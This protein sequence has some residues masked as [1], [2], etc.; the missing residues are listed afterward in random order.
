MPSCSLLNPDRISVDRPSGGG[1][2]FPPLLRLDPFRSACVINPA[3]S[4]RLACRGACL[5]GGCCLE[6]ALLHVPKI[7]DPDSILGRD[8]PLIGIGRL[9]PRISQ[10]EAYRSAFLRDG[11][12]HP[13]RV[14]AASC[15]F[16]TFAE[17]AH[18]DWL[19]SL[20]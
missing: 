19:R 20:A 3:I 4:V 14:S 12:C 6:L 9:C 13:K 1:K 2:P 7:S 17:T 11:G 15:V 5:P 10:Q 18:Q 8:R 16:R